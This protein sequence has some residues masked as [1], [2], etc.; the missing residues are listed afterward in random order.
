MAFCL[1]RKIKGESS[2]TLPFLYLLAVI[3]SSMPNHSA[4]TT[5]LHVL[6][7]NQQT[8]AAALSDLVDCLER[9][10]TGE[11]ETTAARVRHSL[12]SVEESQA[13]VGKCLVEVM[14]GGQT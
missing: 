14:R 13:V 10:E 6:I 8:I 4:T 7:K 9:S 11:L 3:G 2:F 5:L 1:Y 12:R